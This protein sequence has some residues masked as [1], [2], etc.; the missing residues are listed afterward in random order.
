MEQM[1]RKALNI[2]SQKL[3]ASQMKIIT[4]LKPPSALF[5]LRNHCLLQLF[6]RLIKVTGGSHS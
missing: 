5:S 3:G 2:T 1:L 6:S 4:S